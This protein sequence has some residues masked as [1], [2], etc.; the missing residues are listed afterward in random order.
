MDKD[1][2]EFRKLKS[3][4][5]DGNY[6]E[7]DA[8]FKKMNLSQKDEDNLILRMIN[9]TYL[10]SF[11]VW[12]TDRELV[13]QEKLNREIAVLKNFSCENQLKLFNVTAIEELSHKHLEVINLTPKNKKLIK[14][15]SNII[16]AIADLLNDEKFLELD[17]IDNVLKMNLLDVKVNGVIFHRKEEGSTGTNYFKLDEKLFSPKFNIVSIYSDAKKEYLLN[18]NIQ[19]PTI[20][21]VEYLRMKIIDYINNSQH[22]R[23]EDINKVDTAYNKYIIQKS[24][25][26]LN[27]QL[28]NSNS[29]NKKPK[30]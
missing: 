13:K 6:S 14:N 15:S 4:I 24:Y 26:D 10:F 18:K 25:L 12:S 23:Q 1:N 7:I 29:K 30:I 19:L 16:Y 22:F 28:N 21:E 17:K 2:S 9:D 3:F 27:A 5:F 8:W 20:E 11:R